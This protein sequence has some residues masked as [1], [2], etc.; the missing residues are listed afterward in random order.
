MTF[1]SLQDRAASSFYS[2]FFTLVPVDSLR[3]L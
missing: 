1:I 2:G 3:H